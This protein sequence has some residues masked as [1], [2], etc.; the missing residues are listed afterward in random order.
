[1]E[2]IGIG[3]QLS[4]QNVSNGIGANRLDEAVRAKDRAMQDDAGAKDKDNAIGSFQM[5]LAT[6]LVKELRSSLPEGL[7]GGGSGADIYESW[8]DQHIA[9][10]LAES[11]ALGLAG[12]LKAGIGATQAK[13]DASMMDAAQSD[14]NEETG[15]KNSGPELGELLR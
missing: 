3:N 11:D 9:T 1:M 8:F 7:F 12:M 5:L 15:S 10:S 6:Q 2:G 14:E 13:V 4:E